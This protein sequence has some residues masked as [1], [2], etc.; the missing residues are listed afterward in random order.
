MSLVEFIGGPWHGKMIEDPTL[1][2]L[3]AALTDMIG[4]QRVAYSRETY[5]DECGNAT[6]IYL[7]S[8]TTHDQAESYINF[9]TAPNTTQGQK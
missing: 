5:F 2:I 6:V 1:Q 9:G 8:G 3:H 4:S 7:H